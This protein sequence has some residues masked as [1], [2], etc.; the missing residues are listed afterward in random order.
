[1]GLVSGLSLANHSDPGSFLVARASLSQ[2]GFQ[3]KGYWE[4]SSALEEL[5]FIIMG[6]L[7]KP[8]ETDEKDNT[9]RSSVLHPLLQLVPQLH[10]KRM[11]RFKVDVVGSEENKD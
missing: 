6:T 9:K 5:C 8:Q 7:P 2:D 3:R 10:E 11:K 4:A 1:M